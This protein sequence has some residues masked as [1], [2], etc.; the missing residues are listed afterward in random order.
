MSSSQPIDRFQYLRYIASVSPFLYIIMTPIASFIFGVYL[1]ISLNYL[2][3]HCTEAFSSLRIH[4]YKH[5]LRMW[6]S[7]D[8]GDLHVFVIGID[9]VARHWEADPYWDGKLLPK[10]SQVLHEYHS[11]S[12]CWHVYLPGPG[13]VLEV[14]HTEQV[15]TEEREKS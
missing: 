15:P 4:D 10:G 9:H 14:D 12:S 13:A 5:F 11:S 7:P 1:L 8:T 3:Q 2:G 6:I